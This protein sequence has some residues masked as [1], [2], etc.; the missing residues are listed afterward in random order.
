MIYKP[1]NETDDYADND[2]GGEREIKCP[3]LAAVTD[4]AGQSAE[5]ERELWAEI[6][7][8]PDDDEECANGEEDA[9][10]LLRRFHT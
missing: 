5:A 7:Q 3:M 6:E 10:E 1:K 8:S 4:V 9:A 2:G